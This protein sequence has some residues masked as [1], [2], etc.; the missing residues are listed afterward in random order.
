LLDAHL[1]TEEAQVIPLLR[2]DKKF[3]APESD[4]M[5]GL[6]ADGFAW[7]YHGIAPEVL[8]QVSEMLPESITS[9]LADA[10][11]RYDAQCVRVWGSADA[12]ASHTPIPEIW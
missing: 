8:H 11:L 4:E 7:S 2:G 9:K 1:A 10:R 5:A 12:G 6:I 3:P